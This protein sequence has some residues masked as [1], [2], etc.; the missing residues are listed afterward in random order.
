MKKDKI[1]NLFET[2]HSEFDFENPNIGHQ[3]RFL[4]KLKNQNSKYFLAKLRFT[5]LA[6]LRFSHF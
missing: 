6:S 5:L 1:D 2:L 4:S 3:Q